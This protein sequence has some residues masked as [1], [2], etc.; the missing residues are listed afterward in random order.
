MKYLQAFVFVAILS[1]TTSFGQAAKWNLYDY[2]TNE[3]VE[4]NV[5]E[6]TSLDEAREMIENI[7]AVVGLK[8]KFEIKEANIPNAAAVIYGSKRYVLYNSNFVERLNK[9]AGNKWA[10]VSILAHEIG[11]HLNGHTLERGGSRPEI[12]LEADEFSGFVLR[13]M[14][15]T[16]PQAQVAMKVAASQ[17]ASHTHP[18]QK[19]RLYA[20]A[21]GWNA[22]N[23]QMAGTNEGFAR[24]YEKPVPAAIVPV[25][26]RRVAEQRVPN[27]TT[28]E[29]V[30]LAD[31]YISKDVF[32]N[33]SNYYITIRNNFVRVSGNE[34]YVLGKLA[35][36]NNASF[37]YVIVDNRQNILLVKKDGNIFDRNGR[38]VGFLKNHS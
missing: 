10:S 5:H 16:L 14:G 19:D 26:E 36:S 31:K 29:H 30:A 11:H 6:F 24:K 22:A 17:R 37:P 33:S 21:N 35:A 38:R 34:I 12:E 2:H 9:A 4:L 28:S 27:K 32:I 3:N 1:T 7:I 18:A 23:K 20:I 25:R 13:K 8:P 15:A